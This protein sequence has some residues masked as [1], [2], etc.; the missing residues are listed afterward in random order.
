MCTMADARTHPIPAYRQLNA[1]SAVCTH[2]DPVS[3]VQGAGYLHIYLD[4]F[5]IQSYIHT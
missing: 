3:C 2:L 4:K 5:V 1:L